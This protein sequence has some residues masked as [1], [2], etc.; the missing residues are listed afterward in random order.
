MLPWYSYIPQTKGST[1]STTTP[2]IKVTKSDNVRFD[3]TYCTNG[4]W[5]FRRHS[6]K[7]SSTKLQAL[8][9]CGQ[10]FTQTFGDLDTQG[11][12]EF[13]AE[14][15]LDSAERAQTPLTGTKL[16]L[17]SD[18]TDIAFLKVLG[19]ADADLVAV[20][21]RW[22]ELLSGAYSVRCEDVTRMVVARDAAGDVTALVMPIMPPKGSDNWRHVVENELL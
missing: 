18:S 6:A 2:K 12:C 13:G 5:L 22:V 19:E 17:R 3:G 16:R 15:L 11:K 21:A 9:D 1:M 20:D 7:L 14:S 4:K 8:I 10:R